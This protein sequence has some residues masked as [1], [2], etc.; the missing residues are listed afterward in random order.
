MIFTEPLLTRYKGYKIDL[1][2][3]VVLKMYDALSDKDLS[4][5]DKVS[6]AIDLL[7]RGKKPHTVQKQVELWQ[8]IYE[9][10]LK[11]KPIK[12][13]SQPPSFDFEQ[14]ADYIYAAFMQTYGIDLINE[15][16]RLD[17]RRFIS[18]FQGL[19][20]DTKIREIMDIRSKKLP[21]PT[22]YNQEERRSLIEA[23][24]AFALDKSTPENFQ[25]GLADLY[26]VLKSRV[27]GG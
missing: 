23:K 20:E 9:Q 11:P 6:T 13:K 10:F 18:L 5:Q 1:A 15:R 27:K 3:D 7:V 2:Y 21:A 12:G 25:Q 14:D 26:Y 8:G 24:R 4:D 16:G 17:W 22:K 19:P